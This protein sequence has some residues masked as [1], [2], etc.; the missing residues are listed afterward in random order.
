M[1][2]L[3]PTLLLVPLTVC[4]PT[5]GPTTAGE[6]ASD[7]AS[8]SSGETSSGTSSASTTDDPSGNPTTTAGDTETTGTS[9]S[10][11]GGET[12]V[13]PEAR[14]E[15]SI[16]MN[17]A[18][19]NDWSTE[20]PFIDLMKSSRAWQDW[21]G[22]KSELA[23]IDEQGWLT[24]IPGGKSAGLVFLTTLDDQP[25]PFDRFVV[26]WEGAGSLSYHWCAARDDV[27]S[28]DHRDVIDQTCGGSSMMMVQGFEPGD[29]IRN[30]RIIPEPLLADY[31]A[32]EIFNPVWL[33]QIAPF[34]AVRFMDWLATN[35][36]QL[37]SW[38]NRPQ[39]DDRRWTKNGVPLEIAIKL[40]NTINADPWINIPHLAD[41][42]FIRGVVGLVQQ[43]LAPQ[44]VPTFEYSNEVWN[45]GFEQAQ[46]AHTEGQARWGDDVGDAWM[47]YLGM[48]TA[49][50]CDIARGEFYKDTPEAMHCV[51]ST[52]T[53]Y[54]GIAQGA[55]DCPEWVAEGNAPCSQHGV[56]QLG[57]TT[58]FTGCLHDMNN[59]GIMQ[60]W[61][62]EA[63]GGV[64]KGLEQALDGRHFE[65][66][67]TV[68]NLMN[69]WAYF[70]PEASARGMTLVGYEGGSH[71]TAN[72]SGLQNDPEF[73]K[74]HLALNRAPGMGDLY[75][76]MLAS[77]RDGGGTLLMH[78]VDF[79]RP[80]EHG[81][82]GALENLTQKTSPKWD[83]L[84]SINAEPCWW[85][86]CDDG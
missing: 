60:S 13:D 77:W 2:F 55:L 51:V 34:R 47:Q 29:P 66:E 8:T 53:A 14:K 18:G 23:T 71:I 49:Q 42:D 56:D 37:S 78:F 48:R 9:S 32:G 43:E 4:T 61:F 46:Y 27:A 45:W 70:A 65:C 58:Y 20:S 64:Q 39:I 50:L 3:S 15:A 72:G 75:L 21:D 40:A 83:A 6:A 84:S 54:H 74:F 7:S 24:S 52:Q 44:L 25:A 30:I 57:L 33:E 35:N 16:G 31:E 1:K 5:P 22:D 36:S 69:H 80:S 26:M 85:Q 63:D 62:G 12:G 67:D 73:I 11:S 17:L 68:E 41:D 59:A 79:A 76:Q 19:V 81:S 10:S 38:A 28:S 82:W 86:G